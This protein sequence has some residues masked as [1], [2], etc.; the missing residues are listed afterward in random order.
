MADFNAFFLMLFFLH[1]LLKFDDPHRVS[2][3]GYPQDPVFLFDWLFLVGLEVLGCGV[4][5]ELAED[6]GAAWAFDVLFSG[7]LTGGEL[8]E[9]AVAPEIAI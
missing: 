3:L 1:D 8:C 7:L 6:I 2:S 4:S 9:A 5:H